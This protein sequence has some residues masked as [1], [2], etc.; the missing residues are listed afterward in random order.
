M[1][2][3]TGIISCYAMGAGVPEKLELDSILSDY[4]ENIVDI[5][6][7]KSVDTEK[8]TDSELYLNM[9]DDSITVY[10]FSEPVTYIDENGNLK[11]KDNTIDKQK[12]KKINKSGYDFSNGQNDY[13]IHFSSD[14]EKGILI[15]YK[16]IS[17]SISPIST[18]RL[19]GY[20]SDENKENRNSQYFEYKDTFEDGKTFKY[21]P[22]INGIKEE[23]I[24]DKNIGEN[25]FKSKLNVNG[26][27]PKI[28]DDGSISIISNETKEEV[29][30]FIAPFAYDSKY[31]AGIADEHFCADC[32]YKL[33]KVTDDEY[34]L[35]V[36]VS[37][38]WL[39]SKNTAYPVT[40]DPTTSEIYNYADASVYSEKSSLN[41]GSDQ[42]CSF[43]YDEEFGYGRVY[44]RFTV[45]SDIKKYAVIQ[46]AQ[47][48]ESEL[49]GATSVT[50]VTPYM[51][52]SSWSESSIK[53]DNMPEYDPDSAM[54]KKIIDGDSVDDPYD[55]NMYSFNIKSAVEKWI[56]G[57]SNYGIVFISEAEQNNRKSWR[58]FAAQN[59]ISSDYRPFTVIKYVN[60]TRAPKLLNVTGN[61]TEW[62]NEDVT[63]TA[64]ATDEIYSAV[65]GIASYS[66]ATNDSTFTAQTEN[67]K[68]ISS[69]GTYYVRVRDNAGN[70]ST[71]IT[72]K[73]DKIDKASPTKP[74]VSGLPTSRVKDDIVLTIDSTD[75]LSGINAYSISTESGVYNWQTENTKAISENGTYYVCSKD[76][77]GNISSETIVNVNK[78]DKTKPSDPVITGNVTEW[79]N[80]DVILTAT[81]TDENADI[82]EYSFSTSSSSYSWQTEP[83]KAFSNNCTVYTS[84]KDS[85]GDISVADPVVINRI[86]KTLPTTPTVVAHY[87]EDKVVLTASSS[88]SQSGLSEYSF[89]SEEG[90]YNWQ[91]ENTKE[92]TENTYTYIYSKDIAGNIS[93]VKE[94]KVFIGDVTA[95][96][97]TDVTGNV[98]EW[99]NEN[100]V[101]TING[102]EDTETGLHELA[103]SF[104]TSQSSYNWQAENSKAITSNQ[105]VYIHV[106][107]DAGNIAYVDTI[108]VDK[109][110]KSA[111]TFSYN[112]NHNIE[113]DTTTVTITAS[114]SQSGVA[115]YS[116]N[117][118]R[119][120]SESNVITFEKDIY[121]YIDIRVKDNIGNVSSQRILNFYYP[122]CYKE[123]GKIVLY[124]PNP[125]NNG[126]MYYRISKKIFTIWHTYSEP[127]TTDKDTI[128][129]SFV[130]AGLWDTSIANA[131]TYTVSSIPT[132]KPN[133]I[134]GKY[135]ETNTDAS[136][137]YKGINLDFARTYDNTN[138][139]WFFSVNSTIEHNSATNRLTAVF[140]DNTNHTFLP[141]TVNSYY[142]PY[143]DY[144]V[145]VTRTA[146]GKI[147]SYSIKFDDIAYEYNAQGQLCSLANRNG[148]RIHITHSDNSIV[149]ADEAGREYVYRFDDNKNI[150]S[151]TDPAGGVIKY[152]YNSDN[153]LVSVVDQADIYLDTYSYDKNG[154]VS[155]NN[156][157]SIE[158]NSANRIT[159][160]IYDSGA[161]ENYS[162]SG[163]SITTSTSDNETVIT[164][165][166]SYGDICYFES[167]KFISTYMYDSKHRLTKEVLANGDTFT[168]NYNSTGLL[169]SETCTNGKSTYYS[170]DTNNNCIRV[171]SVLNGKTECTYYSYDSFGNVILSASLKE[172]YSGKLPD[173]YDETLT[174]FDTI[175]YSYV[176]GLVKNIINN[177]TNET[178]SYKYDN[179]GN[180]TKITS[181]N[182]ETINSDI[183]CT[184]DVFGN[185]LSYLHDYI[186][187]TY[188]YD[189]A[190]RI[191]LENI[192]GKCN[193]TIYDNRGRVIQK[194]SSEDYDTSKD[195]LP[196]N[197][198]YSDSNVGHRYV[199]NNK[200]QL[201]SE[202]NRFGIT[203]VYT[204]N[205]VG[206]KI[207]ENFDI[208]EFNYLSHGEL[209]NVKVAGSEKVSYNYNEDNKLISANYANG[210]IIRYE[211]DDNGNVIALYHNSNAKPYV[212]YTYNSDA[213][214]I[215]KVNTDTGLKY[216]YGKNGQVSVYKTSDNTLVQSYTETKTE[217]DEKT[218][219]EAKT[220]ITETNFGKSY[221]SVIKE[222]SVSYSADDKTVEY[223]YRTG[224]KEDGEKISS[225]TVKNGDITALSSLYTYNDNGNITQKAI[226]LNGETADF[227][228]SYD[229][230]DKIISSTAFGKTTNYT[231][232]RNDQLVSSK[233][234]NYS[235]SYAY[236]ARGNITVKT[237][238]DETTSFTYANS[239]WKDQLVSVNGTELTYDANGNVL[240]YGDKE[241]LWNTGRHLESITDGD[242]EYRYTYDESG[243]RTSKTVND[244]TTYYNTKDGVILSQTDGTN[245]MYFQ[246][247]SNGIPLGFIFN[248]TQYFYLTNQM[249]DVLGI[250]DA[251]GNKIAEYTYDDWGKLL[252]VN[253]DPE[254]I[255]VTKSNPLRYRGY[256]Y[257][258][259]T[260]YYYLQSRYYDA[261]IC[262]F[263]NADSSVINLTTKNIS[264]SINAYEYC[265]NNPINNV[266]IFGFIAIVDDVAFAAF[267]YSIFGAALE[268]LASVFLGGVLALFAALIYSV[269]ESISSS[270]SSS[271]IPPDDP[272]DKVKKILND[273]PNSLKTSDRNK[274]DL[275]KFDTKLKNGQGK[276][277]SNGWKIQKDTSGHKGSEWKLFDKSGNRIA[278]VKGDG[279]IVGK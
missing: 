127:F 147:A 4:I 73:V 245:T 190:G 157:V 168:Y 93:E 40:I 249:G 141:K 225:D 9:K 144:I 64:N 125:K 38:E 27:F 44:T 35:S 80:Q 88:D 47:I 96:S 83:Y 131:A 36:T 129:I 273:I 51:V 140:P 71:S 248:D 54:E 198:I 50:S 237:V 87:S 94:K 208:Y 58:T 174:C 122:K 203:T 185:E 26:C 162:Y 260:G 33:E 21:Y 6:D 142:D 160:R 20:V 13:K 15:E 169:T 29:Q 134:A 63:L 18:N 276:Q 5:E 214:L 118:G 91:K 173:K 11:C 70:T 78:I 84:F 196:E 148:D 175:N 55:S 3:S 256:Y 22:Q 230:K 201:A 57:T 240:T 191:L 156:D 226:T 268:F 145:D 113:E 77:A 60:D 192:E 187:S 85:N 267:L 95:P 133:Y 103:Y 53:W 193:R 68:T 210:D 10:T 74:N 213:E 106:R 272:N 229:E 271:S 82:A 155:K 109:I 126:T 128:Y 159:S 179:Y 152:T 46:N 269:V 117:G 41:Y 259:E 116:I 72:V 274:I 176:D 32:I 183:S 242:N 234:D 151:L 19:E 254:N 184:Y 79:T 143:S 99:T 16:D 101:L 121:N 166:N 172:G 132:I 23:I 228:N 49:T 30:N 253:A 52:N 235:A 182:G 171:H 136:F 110:D 24:L 263:I 107:D 186:T 105:T 119:T 199:Y 223:S 200:N 124:S 246:Y 204:Y 217:A 270:S 264:K 65:S 66:F 219:A 167:N 56:N 189:F 243:I 216:V 31:T 7:V 81:P 279:T 89:S 164:Q 197:N 170:Y 202:T 165:Y 261:D 258:N 181:T 42:T 111:P 247:N 90:V 1:V 62:T 37:E 28:N 265:Y 115:A 275:S 130:P 224:G 149:A 180:A 221:S 212:T 233:G 48:W 207:C 188:T 92:F 138:N 120:W 178:K 39:N 241:Y 97:F 150:V 220:E 239:G 34:I 206:N 211:Y 154:R 194:V 135:E 12:D 43:G 209:S 104:S 98:T 17:F 262:R 257:D 255:A 25:V 69:N 177:K 205:N 8:T 238:N 244:I 100:V 231:Y 61:P 112:Y 222:K 2:F 277:A 139:K 59:Y 76:N 86:D 108:T 195:G 153:K 163:N 236:D 146:D 158:Y 232:D 45:P 278:S 75:A 102:A 266:D 161:Y 227:I 218:G 67:T 123:N 14:S 250:V 114:D 251:D 137:A 252:S 215:E